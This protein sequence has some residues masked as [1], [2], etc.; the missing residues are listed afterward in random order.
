MPLKCTPPMLRPANLSAANL[1][2]KTADAW[3]GTPEH[4]AWSRAVIKRAGHRCQ[5]CGRTETRLFADHI[6]EIVDGG[7]RLDPANGRALCGRHHTIKT[8][9]ARVA[10]LASRG[11]P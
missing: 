5:E 1:P 8:A 4:R 9:K 3:Y 7:A 2:P 6:V 11:S 10:R